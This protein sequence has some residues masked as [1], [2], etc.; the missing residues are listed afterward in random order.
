MFDFISKLIHGRSDAKKNDQQV[1]ATLNTHQQAEDKHKS[2]EQERQ[3]FLQK[4]DAAAN[5][6]TILIELLGQCDFADGRF[7][8]AQKIVSQSGMV[9]VLP[10]MR[11]LDKRVAKLLQTRL[12][13]ISEN[14]QNDMA[15]Q[16]CVAAADSLLQQTV[17][18]S[19]QL[20][21]LDKRYAQ[22]KSFSEAVKAQ[23]QEKRQALTNRLSQ[24]IQ[25]QQ[26]ILTLMQ[27]FEHVEDH[28][29]S[30]LGRKFLDWQAKF[31]AC[32]SD[33]NAASLPKHLLIECQLKLNAI[34]D[35]WRR[36]NAKSEPINETV[37]SPE[38]NTPSE[39]C[40]NVPFGSIGQGKPV[41][42][43][44]NKKISKPHLS[45]SLEQ[46]ES[47]LQQMEAALEQGSV[48]NAR[49]FDRELRDLDTKQSYANIVLSV[50]LKE[51]VNLARKELLHLLSWAKW[52]GNASRDELVNT[53]E[54]LAGLKLSPKEIVGTVSALREQWKQT[55]ASSGAA[56]K[57]LWTRFDA[58][59]N[60]AYAPATQF[61]S[62]QNEQRRANLLQ[63]ETKLVDWQAQVQALLTPVLDSSNDQPE[64][65]DWKS[66]VS[67]IQQMQQNWRGLG[68]VD[69][70]DKNRLDK[71]FDTLLNQLRQPL[72]ARQQEEVA[73]REALILSASQLDSAQKNA[74]DQLRQLQQRWQIQAASVPLPRKDD[75]ALWERFR[76]A[77]DAVF[78]KKRANVESADKLRQ[79]NL[80]AKEKICL[81]LQ[82]V[83][84]GELNEVQKMSGLIA[85][86]RSAWRQL[87]QVPRADE[88]QIETKFQA[89]LDGM[90]QQMIQ[91]QE[92]IEREKSQQI[93]AKLHTCLQVEALLSSSAIDSVALQTLK[94]DWNT[95]ALPNSPIS[96]NLQKKFDLV[97]GLLEPSDGVADVGAYQERAN[98]KRS[99][100]EDTL[101]HLEILLGVDS[102]VELRRE[103]LQK[104]VQVLQSS[105]KNGQDKTQ[106]LELLNHLLSLPLN[107]D[108]KMQQRV[109]T[110]F[111][112]VNLKVQ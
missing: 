66:I 88:Q 76:A 8:V 11:K 17:I 72:A 40:V 59:C 103:R 70:K 84:L 27:E 28:A 75:Q 10:A 39:L 48:Q 91:L 58:A 110:L 30:D 19:N 7:Q 74:V 82:Q 53:A 31:D 55:E 9:K 106:V 97:C 5:D 29:A 100:I 98:I 47:S 62:E 90:Q 38:N 16:A 89:L 36:A 83:S 63:A 51:R 41:N 49:Q 33:E 112:K 26:R 93:L 96:K 60:A 73:L 65:N 24:Q 12:D 111:H 1:A 13:E 56:S 25:L 80:Q 4:V 101:L 77:C 21:D 54:G 14:S 50:E 15:A 67:T 104:Q 45:L 34:Q 81:E 64:K 61:F 94:H 52:S 20:V 69:R 43:P 44:G 42:K 86:A 46:I 78:E 23:F 2:R 22:V 108:T 35:N 87:G 32:S 92:R 99:E 3:L 71:E 6:E 18:L 37:S 107:V 95:D 102:P 57:E 68:H 79:E 85:D 109:E 105:L